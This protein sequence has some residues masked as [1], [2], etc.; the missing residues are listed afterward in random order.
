MLAIN[1][2]ENRNTVTRTAVAQK[3]PFPVLMDPT[4]Q[5]GLRYGMRGVPA[6]FLID[7][8]GVLIGEASGARFWDDDQSREAFKKIIQKYKH[9]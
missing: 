6:H 1:L 8:R 2:R 7:D 9:N 4:G 3:L 5:T